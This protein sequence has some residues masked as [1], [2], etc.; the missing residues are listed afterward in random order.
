MKPAAEASLIAHVGLR[1]TAREI[2]YDDQTPAAARETILAVY[3]VTP[4]GSP[5]SYQISCSHLRPTP[6]SP[7]PQIP[8]E[9][10]DATHELI[11]APIVPTPQGPTLITDPN[12]STSSQVVLHSDRQG[13]AL[14]TLLM[15]AV[16]NG[17]LTLPAKAGGYIPPAW[18]HAITA[19]VHHVRR[20]Q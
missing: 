10:P 17:P 6:A 20:L 15:H 16:L 12:W 11:I 8:A 4:H 1:A 5:A 14:A 2:G 7:A 13:E 18:A 19:A 3:V 9:L